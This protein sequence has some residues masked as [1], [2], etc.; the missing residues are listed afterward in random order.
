MV[1]GDYNHHLQESTML[2]QSHD[3]GG[4][5][6]LQALSL[7]GDPWATEV[8]PRLPANLAEQA[9]ALKAFQRVRGLATPH[10]LLRGVLAYV[11]GPLSTRRLGAWAVLT[12]LADISE[13]AWRKRLRVSNDWLLWL[14]GELVAAPE[15]PALPCPR[16]AGRLVLVD[17]STLGQ[18]G[19]T[20]D[21]WRLHLAYDL[22]AGR[23]H[24]VGVTDRRGG[25]HLERY[26]WH[27]GEVI[28]A[29]RGYGYRRSVATAVRQQADVV[30]RIHPATFPLE[31]EAGQLFNVLG[32]LRHRGGA[33][34]AWH[35][36]C[37]WAGQ[38]Y[39]VRLVAAKLDATATRCA[40]HRARRKAQKAG[41]TI[42]APTLAV[43]GWLLLITTLAVAT[44]ATADVLYVYRARWQVELVFK[45]MKQLLRLNQI[46]SKHRTSVEATVRALLIAWAL[47]E[48]TTTWLRTLLRATASP[49]SVVVSSWL[50]SGLG[51]DTLRQQVQ[52]RWSEA[53]LQACLPRLHRFLCS[54]PR[55]RGCQESIVRTWLEQRACARPDRRPK[56]A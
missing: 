3:T 17:A 49:E 54:R 32:W 34:R 44:W 55:R 25:E 35:G 1:L 42:T 46:R 19:G 47:H 38:R 16:P 9:R 8:V 12:G 13:A 14:L 33:A 45:K 56:A 48:S 36:W 50:V 21:D 43:A 26:R 53:H 29:D 5:V 10:D 30:V 11:L 6:A 23:M 39:P 22:L 40:R 4:L 31:T 41:R 24:Q 7:V 15:A 52:G 2:V 37:R 51:L 20:G 18:P 28:V 27:A